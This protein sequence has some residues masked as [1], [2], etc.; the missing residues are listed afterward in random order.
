MDYKPP[1]NDGLGAKFI[2]PRQV[3]GQPF[4]TNAGDVRFFGQI[5]DKITI[6][7]KYKL[8][9]MMYEGELEY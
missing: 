2:F 4:L 7:T 6:S 3:D 9:E 1:T 8:Q 5:G